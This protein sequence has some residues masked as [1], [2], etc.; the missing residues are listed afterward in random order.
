MSPTIFSP[1]RSGGEIAAHEVGDAVLLAVAL[2]KA[3]PPRP[4]LARAPGQLTHQGP[5]QLG[6]GPDA[7]ARQ[8][9]VDPPVPVRLIRIIE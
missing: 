9:R 4:W 8:V 5:H 1:G 3:E 6:P 2:R 7:P